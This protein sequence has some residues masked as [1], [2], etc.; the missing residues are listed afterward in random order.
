MY[1]LLLLLLCRNVGKREEKRE[2]IE[3]WIVG[4]S[5]E[6]WNSFMKDK[7]DGKL[8]LKLN[9]NFY[10]GEHKANWHKYKWNDSKLD[11]YTMYTLIEKT[12]YLFGR[13]IMYR[14]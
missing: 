12:G 10:Q 14:L 4:M 6:Y 1:T 8:K 13:F 5:T 9:W 7:N 3:V 2:Y 11:Y